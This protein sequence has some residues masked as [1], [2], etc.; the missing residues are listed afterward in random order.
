MA[1]YFTFD[2]VESTIFNT[3]VANSNMFDSPKENVESIQIAGSNRIVHL[4]NGT[5][6]PFELEVECYIPRSMKNYIDGIRNYL[7]FA[8]KS[9]KYYESLRPNEYRIA[10]Y[11]RAFEVKASDR[12]GAAFNLIFECRPERFLTSGDETTTLTASGS[13]TNPTNFSSKP[14][15]KVYGTGKFTIGTYE[16]EITSADEYTMI[17]CDSMQC[18]KGDVNCN[19]NV[20]G[21]LPVLVPGDN[22][23]TLDG[24]TQIDIVPRW[25]TV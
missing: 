3:Y 12:Q 10:S 21:N 25:W 14:L 11:V 5:F 20:V 16:L 8:K 1:N 13:I 19:K 17:D 15:L 9:V 22:A 24:I 7:Q 23:I 18:Y 6:A 4:S 2:G